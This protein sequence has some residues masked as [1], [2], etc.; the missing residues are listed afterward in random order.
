MSS[1]YTE[2]LVEIVWSP[3]KRRFLIRA[4]TNLGQA[5]IGAG[6]LWC[7]DAKTFRAKLLGDREVYKAAWI[8]SYRV[9]YTECIGYRRNKSGISVPLWLHKKVNV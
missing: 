7:V 4:G 1:L 3:D 5:S 6:N 9:S 2:S 8:S